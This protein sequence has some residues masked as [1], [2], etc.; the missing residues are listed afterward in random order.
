M[1]GQINSSAVWL[2]SV[3]GSLECSLECL[4]IDS[5]RLRFTD[6]QPGVGP[7]MLRLVGLQ[8]QDVLKSVRL[9]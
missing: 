5:H 1:Q 8:L 2:L 9:F 3:C 7:R 6:G 4:N